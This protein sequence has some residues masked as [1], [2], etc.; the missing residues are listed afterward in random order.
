MQIWWRTRIHTKCSHSHLKYVESKCVINVE[1]DSRALAGKFG[2][3]WISMG[4]AFVE[5]LWQ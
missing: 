2:C 4:I 5:E 1:E 3:G